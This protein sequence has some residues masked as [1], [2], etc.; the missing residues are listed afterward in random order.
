MDEQCQHLTPNKLER[1]PHILETFESMFDRTLGTWKTPPVNLDLK[2]DAT[3]MSLRP[4]PVP[5]VHKDMVVKE[6]ER[7]VKLGFLEEAN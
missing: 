7:I 2:D 3:P 5:R 6:V 4:H 1:L